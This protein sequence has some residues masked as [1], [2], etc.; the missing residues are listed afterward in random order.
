M[1]TC[2]HA[3]ARAENVTFACTCVR[4]ATQAGVRRAQTAELRLKAELLGNPR[5]APLPMA[6]LHS[7]AVRA[8]S[9][10]GQTNAGFTR[11]GNDEVQFFL[12]FK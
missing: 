10:V 5:R 9:I 2:L 3:R 8:W 7:P 6:E 12:R 1:C 4:R 11:S